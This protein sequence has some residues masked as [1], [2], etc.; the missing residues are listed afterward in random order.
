MR[1]SPL[2][3]SDPGFLSDPVSE[4]APPGVVVV[5]GG[6]VGVRAA[7]EIARRGQPVTLLTAEP[8]QPYNR[9]RLTPLLAGDVQFGEIEVPQIGGA[10]GV[11]CLTGLPV[12]A[13]DR[14]ARQVRTADGGVW[15]Y[16]KLV[17][18]TGSRAFVP[19]IPG[20]DLTGVYTFRTAADASA[21]LARSFSARKV[22]VI[23]GGLLG[24]EAAR[25]MRQRQ[26]EVT[27]I[28]HEGRVMPRQL[29]AE[30][31]ALLAQSIEALGVK[32]FTGVAVKSIAGE[33]GKVTGLA[34]AN[35]TEIEAD[36]VI[37]CTG[38]RANT[39]IALAAGLPVGRGVIVND[40]MQTADPDIY[41]IGECAEHRG[42]VYGLV[43]PGYAQADVAAAVL[44]GG[45]A[46]YSGTAPATKLKVIGAEV[47]SAGEVEQLDARPDVRSHVW[48]GPDGYRR[49]FLA[50]GKL[51][52]AMAVGG[53]DQSSRVQNAVQSEM[54]VHPWQ[55]W[56]FR[57]TG[58]LWPD[59][60][61]GVADLPEEA[62]VCNC[63][64]V[65]AGRLRACQAA[66]AG[67]APALSLATGAGTVCGSCVPQLEELADAGGPPKPVR[68]F[69]A[70]IALSSLAALL[71]LALAFLPR[72]PY[73]TSFDAA[74]LRDWLW[75]DPIVKQW[76][77]WT[78]FGI[79]VAAM[80]VGLRKRLRITDRLGAYD[81]WRVIHLGIGL[82]AAIALVVHTGLRP[83][84]NANLALFVAFTATLVMGAVAGMATGGDHALRARR[85][86]T[87]R[88]PARALPTWLHILAIWPLP[89]LILVHVLTVYAY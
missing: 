85:I 29:D 82:L 77:G 33:N 54:P 68:L 32:V 11:T 15:P 52:G 89:V 46:S 86:G 25:G 22:V 1:I 41:A 83:G 16:D 88:K 37:I 24:L 76:T 31:G 26:A 17:L 55:V 71:A 12:T 49:I 6:P 61:L 13:I 64:G 50:R 69:K 27:V 53:W 65:T 36:T 9:V 47:F 43:G 78:L 3:L 39:Q 67:D 81:W 8:Y 63:T 51:K 21:L 42:Q 60:D 4:P 23:G 45:T 62:T 20:A 35:G 2:S 74:S 30:A 58:Q 80:A 79:A 87:A 19:S 5:G 10:E 72:V 73:P 44:S 59:E 40:A 66:G 56:R 7:N 84:A 70:L 18:A 34:L 38:V 14:D 48:R 28:E 75:R 57:T